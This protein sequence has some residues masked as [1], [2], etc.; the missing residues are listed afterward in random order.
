[1]GRN[2]PFMQV[3]CVIGANAVTPRV[4]E[5]WPQSTGQLK[6]ERKNIKIK[7]VKKKK[8]SKNHVTDHDSKI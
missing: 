4:F 1:M 8:S 6:I 5:V 2:N 7:I 3:V